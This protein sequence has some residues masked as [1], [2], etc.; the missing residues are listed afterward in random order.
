LRAYT[1][2]RLFASVKLGVAGVPFSLALR[3]LHGD[4]VVPGTFV[5]GFAFGFS[6]GLAELFVLRGWLKELPFVAHLVAKSL[7]IVAVMYVAFAVLNT[8][9]VILEGISWSEYAG[10][11]VET[12]TAVGLLEALAVIAFLLFFVQLDRLLGPGVLVG[13]LTGR[14]HHPRRERRIFM[15]LDLKGSTRLADGMEADRYFAF[16]HRYFTQMSEPIL[17][18][19]AEI[20]QYVGDEVVL[21]WR[22][23]SGLTEAS[24][25]RA[26]FLIEDRM[27]AH[28]EQFLREFGV[29]PEFKAG[30]HA[31]EVITAQIGE[32]KSEI[33]YNGDVLN[34]TARIQ[35]ACNELGHRLLVS[36]ELMEQ[37]TLGPDLEVEHLGPITLRGKD[38]AVPL[39]AVTKRNARSE[40]T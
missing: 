32:L 22:M 2:R 23:Q 30:V 11:L 9:D 37:L 29:A 39:C 21:T 16:L 27:R 7:A 35:A 34:V 36:A 19:D 33:V 8:L 4:P 1:R 25:I 20:Y 38:E 17:E 13:Y 14:Y 15:F 18:T 31:G 40:T 26:Y 24:C 6:V 12:R 3:L 10:I 5:L 28:R